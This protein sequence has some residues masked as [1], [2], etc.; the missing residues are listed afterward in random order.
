M[1]EGRE[2][3]VSRRGESGR[4]DTEGRGD[5]E[6]GRGEIEGRERERK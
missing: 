6:W 1:E 3:G 2:G 5:S 4:E